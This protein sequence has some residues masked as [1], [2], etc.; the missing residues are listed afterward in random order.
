M[1]ASKGPRTTP[2]CSEKGRRR[3]SDGFV[4]GPTH[5]SSEGSN[6]R[7]K[8]SNKVERNRRSSW[9]PGE[10]GSRRLGDV[11][12]AVF[13]PGGG[14]RGSAAVSIEQEARRRTEQEVVLPKPGMA[15]KIDP[16]APPL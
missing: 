12:T 15:P 6:G 3:C 7:F 11:A 14:D 2:G 8:L 5:F 13:F 16:M 9:S 1:G 10:F 4:H